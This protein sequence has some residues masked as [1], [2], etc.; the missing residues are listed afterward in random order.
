MVLPLS[1]SPPRASLAAPEMSS[2][3]RPPHAAPKPRRLPGPRRPCPD[4]RPPSVSVSPPTIQQMCARTPLLTIPLAPRGRRGPLQGPTVLDVR[5]SLRPRPSSPI[6]GSSAPPPSTVVASQTRA[7]R[8][9]VR[10]RLARGTPSAASSTAEPTPIV[11][12]EIDYGFMCLSDVGTLSWRGTVPSPASS[13]WPTRSPCAR[14]ECR[15]QIPT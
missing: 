10:T 13:G 15:A 11:S 2:M 14:R 6:T 8:T 9:A 12:F 4:R 3:P 7:T 1:P 5:P